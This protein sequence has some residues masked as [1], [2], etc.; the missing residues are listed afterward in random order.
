MAFPTSNP[1]K[2]RSSPQDW[3]QEASRTWNLIFSSL[4]PILGAIYQYLSFTQYLPCG[5]PKGSEGS[6]GAVRRE[7]SCK[8]YLWLARCT[9][10]CSLWTFPRCSRPLLFPF[11]PVCPWWPLGRAKGGYGK[12]AGQGPCIPLFVSWFGSWAQWSCSRGRA[13]WG[14]N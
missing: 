14:P 6:R 11:C 1:L 12:G 2:L 13:H 5:H 7:L 4:Q 9:V 10:S 8:G 3:L